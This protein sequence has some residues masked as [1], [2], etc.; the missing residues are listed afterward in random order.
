[1]T[2]YPGYELNW[3]S[4]AANGCRFCRSTSVLPGAALCGRACARPAL[5]YI[6]DTSHKAVCLLTHVTILRFQARQTRHREQADD[7]VK[8]F[9]RLPGA[10]IDASLPAKLDAHAVPDNPAIHKTACIHRWLARPSPRR[11][12]A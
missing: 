7:T 5:D 3:S 4:A 11:K 6:K 2:H 9:R 1:M 8:E 12:G 10:A